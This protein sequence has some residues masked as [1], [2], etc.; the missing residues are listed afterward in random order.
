MGSIHVSQLGKAYKQYPGRWSRLLEWVT[1]FLGQRHR[2]KWVLQD[3]DFHIA[4]GESV[5]LIGVNGAGKSTLLKLITGT[6]QPTTGAVTTHG[7]VAALLELGMGFHPDFTGRQNAVMAGQ[8]IG[9]SVEEVTALMPGIE[10]FAEIGDY[11]DQPVRV[12]SSGMQVRLAFAVA[13]AVRPDILV[14]DEALAVGDVFFQ[15]KCYERIRAY[16]QAGTTLLFV[17]HAMG[18]VYSLCNRAIL[19]SAGRV[20]L[21][22][23]PREVIDLYN[24]HVLHQ[25]EG[26]AP[27]PAPVRTATAEPGSDAAGRAADGSASR[28]APA[29]SSAPVAAPEAATVPE[30][31]G[32]PPTASATTAADATAPSTVGS[33]AH[34]GATLDAVGLYVDDQP[35]ATIVSDRVA[36]VRVESRFA[37]GYA[38]PHIGFQIRNARGEAVFMTNTYCMG[39]R[40]GPV[41]PGEAVRAEFSFKA[42]LAPGDYTITAGVAEGGAGEGDFRQTLARQQ[43][44]SAFTV[45]RNLDAIVW[46][47]VCNLDPI[48]ELQR[49]AP[50]C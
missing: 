34:G 18:A 46:S 26:K 42:S 49:Q 6:A 3:I 48:C 10:A 43:D 19:I 12:Y 30:P 2:L 28:Q 32:T 14:I 33:F 23:S 21:D 24:A 29:D 5:A 15:Q 47:G 9:L 25:R 44:A 37:Q 13:T 20:A 40:I 35:A 16:C 4:A 50:A 8:L 31:A 22:S 27:P 17:S 11:I 45:L 7:R 1:P 36:T 39:Q 41:A 38:D